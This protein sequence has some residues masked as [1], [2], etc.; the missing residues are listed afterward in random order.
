[1]ANK[2]RA[3]SHLENVLTFRRREKKLNHTS[4]S[5]S[6][7]C[8]Q[9]AW[10][11]AKTSESKINGKPFL[12]RSHFSYF[13]I[14]PRSRKISTQYER[15]SPVLD[16]PTSSPK[17]RKVSFDSEDYYIS[18]TPPSRALRRQKCLA[19]LTFSAR[20]QEE[21]E[22]YLSSGSAPPSSPQPAAPIDIYQTPPLCLDPHNGPHH[23]A[24]HMLAQIDF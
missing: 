11:D 24:Q 18:K 22:N 23:N 20:F 15:S 6:S 16:F 12:W 21:R 7:F 9:T 13:D 4:E 10:K 8:G 19:P 3:Q 1:M 2:I 5:A 17:W 14:W